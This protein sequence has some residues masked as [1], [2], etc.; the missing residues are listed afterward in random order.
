M[1]KKSSIITLAVIIVLG[2]LV[3]LGVKSVGG[4]AGA[5]SRGPARVLVNQARALEDKGSLY[6]AKLLFQKLVD[7]YPESAEVVVWQKKAEDLNI[8]LLFSP[9]ITPKSTVYQIKPG[10]TLNKISHDYKTTMELIQKS[11]KIS[12]SLIVPGRKIKIWNAPFNIL[13]DKSQNILLLKSD[14]EVVKTYIVS[15]GKNNCT[16]VGTFKITNKLPNPTWFKAGF[17]KFLFNR[18]KA[19]P[20]ACRIP[21][22]MRLSRDFSPKALSRGP[23]LKKGVSP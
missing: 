16:P 22:R 7:D 2:L 18:K 23:A 13:V 5:S 9:T 20:W 14:E 4:A 17:S 10:D 15:T 3:F 8:K 1:N 19:G 11:N 12:D 21:C 6:E